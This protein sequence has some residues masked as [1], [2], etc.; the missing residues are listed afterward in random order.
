LAP[1]GIRPDS[2]PTTFNIFMNVGIDVKGRLAVLPPRSRAGG[3]IELG[4]EMDLVVGV[5][6]CSAELSNNY[7]FKPILYETYGS[8]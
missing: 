6:A 1:F 5:T 7:C 2:I 8:V 3:C 4:A